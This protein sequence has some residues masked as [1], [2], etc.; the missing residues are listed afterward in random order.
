MSTTP[1]RATPK[2]PSPKPSASPVRIPSPLKSAVDQGVTLDDP[3][4]TLKQ[5]I[6]PI[7]VLGLCGAGAVY[8]AKRIGDLEHKVHAERR[9]DVR[10]LTDSDVQLIVSFYNLFDKHMNEH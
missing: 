9:L 6:G 2:M 10:H 3:V 1:Q 8:F 4:Q 5:Y 7:A